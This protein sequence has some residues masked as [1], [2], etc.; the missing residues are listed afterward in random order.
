[1]DINKVFPSPTISG[2][3]RRSWVLSY[4]RY[5][6]L[7]PEEKEV[8]DTNKSSYSPKEWSLALHIKATL[9]QRF[10]LRHFKIAHKLVREAEQ[11][12][13]QH[14]YPG[15]SEEVGYNEKA[16]AKQFQFQGFI[17]LSTFK[18]YN[19]SFSYI[20]SNRKINGTFWIYPKKLQSGLQ[21]GRHL[22]LWETFSK[23]GIPG[24]TLAR[25]SGKS[26]YPIRELE[27]ELK[28]LL[29]DSRTTQNN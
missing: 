22:D 10:K 17:P 4:R 27:L 1:M 3:E 6:R 2:R 16:L 11:Y 25:Q 29:D 14:G 28:K 9:K 21:Q 13:L 18:R 19:E 15:H 12:Y 24:L 20:I 26:N 23:V 8:F 7:T 5:E